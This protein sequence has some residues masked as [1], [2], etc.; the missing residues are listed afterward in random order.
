M[1]ITV[2]QQRAE[3]STQRVCDSKR[4]NSHAGR[5]VGIKEDAKTLNAYLNTLQSKVYEAHRFL[6][7]TNEAITAEA[8]K[9]KAVGKPER[10]RLLMEVFKQ[11]N[12]QME[13]LVE[14]QEYAMG[15]LSHFETSYNMF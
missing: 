7:E 11:H 10:P 3:L 6:V 12:K 9:N 14:N 15:T 1:R 13:K 4:W 5:L 2:D 8:L